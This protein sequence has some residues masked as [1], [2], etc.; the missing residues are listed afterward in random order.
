MAH[1]WIADGL[2]ILNI[3]VGV[4]NKLLEANKISG[5]VGQSTYTEAACFE[6]LCRVL[7]VDRFLG[8]IQGTVNDVGF[9]TLN[10]KK[11]QQENA[12]L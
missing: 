12:K 3:T 7:H 6:M 1:Y 8:M 10:V 11:Q 9:V 2:R 5:C 4:V